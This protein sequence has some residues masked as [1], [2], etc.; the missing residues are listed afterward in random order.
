MDQKKDLVEWTVF[1]DIIVFTEPF[2]DNFKLYSYCMV[3][4]QKYV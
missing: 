4:L 3:S 1:I 2:F